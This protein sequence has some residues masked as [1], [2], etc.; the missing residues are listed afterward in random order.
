MQSPAGQPRPWYRS[1]KKLMILAV[2]LSAI[3][4]APTVLYYELSY[5][6]VNGT[7]PELVTGYRSTSYFSATF[8]ITV[9]V[10]S[11]AGSID[12][13][14]TSPAFTLT[15]NNL[16]FGTQIATSSTFSPNNYVSYSLSFTTNDGS[17]VQNVRSSNTTN[18]FLQMSAD[19][20]SGWYHELITKSDSAT[21]TFR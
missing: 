4:I 7:H 18:L 5:N 14:V 17:I 21:W 10:W 9:H 19:V 13:Q 15:A 12:T 6:S 11:W 8:Y 16:P 1:N 3:I 2:I 20:S